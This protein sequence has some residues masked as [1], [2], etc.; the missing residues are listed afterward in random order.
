MAALLDSEHIDMPMYRNEP[1]L[2]AKLWVTNSLKSPD[3]LPDAAEVWVNVPEYF[4]GVTFDGKEI[5]YDSC[6]LLYANLIQM[7]D[8]FIEDYNIMYD[9]LSEAKFLRDNLLLM[10]DKLNKFIDQED[11]KKLNIR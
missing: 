4:K 11:S 6:G 9:N 7:T 10:V 2:R 3:Y 1:I 5:E 8:E